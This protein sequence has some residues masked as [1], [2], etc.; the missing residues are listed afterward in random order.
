MLG[1]IYL[2]GIGLSGLFIY[3]YLVGHKNGV[4]W[5]R[6]RQRGSAIPD[7]ARKETVITCPRCRADMTGR[8]VCPKCHY[9]DEEEE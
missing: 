8:A 3:A 6:H 4:E 1:A 5:E 9:I 2:M 7:W